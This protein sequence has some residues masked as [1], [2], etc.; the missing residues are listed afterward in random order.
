MLKKKKV[1]GRCFNSVFWYP[2]CLEIKY[3]C[4]FCVTT[5]KVNCNKSH[6]NQKKKREGKKEDETWVTKLV[7][8]FDDLG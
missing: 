6:N 3:Y 1:K 5:V 7:L 2:F 8:V 4:Y